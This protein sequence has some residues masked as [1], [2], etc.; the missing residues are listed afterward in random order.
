PAADVTRT[1][2]V[3]KASGTVV[4]GDL[5]QTYDGTPKAATATT[6]PPGLTVNFTYN[7]SATAPTQTGSY[8]V[9]ATIADPIYAGSASGS[10]VIE[11][12]PQ[13]IDFPAIADQL[14]TATVNLE[15]TGGASGNAVTF[16]VTS[17]S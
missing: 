10:F 2:N 5:V 4:L 17:G 16:A 8:G 6:T 1:F 13:V 12:A 15:A 9:V 11:K 3:T 7:G 14:T